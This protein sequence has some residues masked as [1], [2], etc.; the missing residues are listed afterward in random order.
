MHAN[1]TCVRRVFNL[2][3][4]AALF[5]HKRLTSNFCGTQTHIIMST[6]YEHIRCIESVAL[7]T[8]R[9]LI[10]LSCSYSKTN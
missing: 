5:L 4:S 8:E 2:A 6:K 1:S 3:V 10:I 9:M 7:I